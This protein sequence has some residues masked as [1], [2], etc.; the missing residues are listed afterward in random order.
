MSGPNPAASKT[1]TKWPKENTR[2]GMPT[3]LYLVKDA[4]RTTSADSCCYS[5]TEEDGDKEEDQ[6]K[7]VLACFHDP[8]DVMC[9]P[10]ETLSSNSNHI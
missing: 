9:I 5:D 10:F 3:T 4:A 8:K 1:W 7:A 2:S 6:A